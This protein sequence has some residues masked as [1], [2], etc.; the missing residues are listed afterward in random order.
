MPEKG[1]LFVLT[2]IDGSG[3]ATQAG[4]LVKTLRAEG[5]PV[6]MLDFPRYEEGFHGRMVARYL[7]G[8]FGDASQVNPYLAS[9]MFAGD[10]WEAKDELLRHE[11]AGTVVVCN[12][13]AL[14]AFS[15]RSPAI[16]LPFPG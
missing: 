7:R 16:F 14:K 4:L 1:K 9:L 12:R 8:E 2:G 13:Y 10:R 3:K 6:A 15:S 11:S 5:K